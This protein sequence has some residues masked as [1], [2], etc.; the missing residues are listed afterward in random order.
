MGG[1]LKLMAGS[2]SAGAALVSILSYT[3]AHTAPSAEQV[4]RLAVT[5]A[6]DT[7]YSI[8][9]SLQL[10]AVLT[11][12]RGAALLGLAPSWT[13]ADPQVAIVDQAGTVVSR[14]TGSTAIIVRVGALE[15]RAR[16]VVAQRAAALQLADTLLRV[17]EGEGARP[18][19]QAVDAR[20]NPIAVAAVRW[21]S[22]D[23]VVASVDSTGAVAGVS[24]GRS[25]LTA[26]FDQL[27]AVLPVEVVPVPASIT[28]M[29]GEDQRAPAGQA[30][31][32]PVT[33]QI[34]SRS[35]RPIPGI[36]VSLAVRDGI[37]VVAP[38]V[39][40]SD[41]RGMVQAVW[42]LGAVPGRQQLALSVEGVAVSPVLTAEADPLAANTRVSLAGEPPS[43]A[44][45]DSLREPVVVRVTDSA[46]TAIP[47]LPVVWSAPDGGKTLPLGVRTDSLGETRAH[48]VLGPRAGRQRLRVQV[49]N[50]RLMPVFT[51]AGVAR[52]GA[53]VSIVVAGGDRQAGTVEKV[54]TKP[55]VLRALDRHGNPVAGAPIAIAASAGRTSD[56]VVT[57]DSAGQ[58]KVRWTLGPL[59][60]A[61]RFTAQLAAG[62]S[63]VEA[64]ARAR[65]GAPAKLAF[66]APPS[67]A[68]AGR[69][70]ARP[71]VV[72]VTDRLGNPL[73][74]RTVLF[75]TG[76][77]T[78]SPARAVTDS[79]G[80]A[81]VRW[82]PGTRPGSVSLVAKVASTDLR[83]T[84]TLTTK[85]KARPAP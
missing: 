30:L 76:S 70:L 71:V 46:G 16:I 53:P 49:G 8:G 68:T 73:A 29:G 72:E 27:R 40:T 43:A 81:V 19:A 58:A 4:H 5:P 62:K 32:A 45:G 35:G 2:L 80:H 44:A 83:A 36:A 25:T 74:G 51:V 31:P 67:S 50:A 79:L 66:V 6:R 60:G 22:A 21:E 12:E 24:P 15:T 3:R 33:A 82:T 10:A 69:A 37:G 59:A 7:V 14:G 34:V 85:V 20:G 9:D 1:T 13:T 55:L 78:R 38:E 56:S 18:V 57:T 64:T 28:I 23:A 84:L 41:A 26:T 65:A 54:L 63:A 17:A 77:G 75:S 48:W 61:Q 52:P 39:D 47:D 42:T 11:D